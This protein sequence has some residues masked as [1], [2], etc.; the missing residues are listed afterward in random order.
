[1]STAYSSAISAYRKATTAVP[2]LSA[3][4]LLYDE[5][6]NSVVHAACHVRDKEFEQAHV[7]TQ[8][9]VTILK[10]L[11]QNLDME[12]GGEVSEQLLDTYSKN[13]L[14][15]NTTIGKKDAVERY[16]SIAAG[17]LELRNAWSKMTPFSERDADMLFI[18]I[19]GTRE[20]TPATAGSAV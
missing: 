13:I 4:V 19:D 15:L 8:K 18:D 16:K 20:D 9:A 1:M 17:L 12:A 2:P 11:R 14:A 7:R 5:V 6:L 10:G 3:V